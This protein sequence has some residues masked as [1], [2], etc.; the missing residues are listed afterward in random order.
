MRP[1]IKVWIEVGGRPVFGDGKLRWLE[2]IDETG[3]LRAA[4]KALAMSYRGL[5]G[6]LRAAEQR[7]GFRLIARR[8]G[9]AGG[10]GVELTE[11][12][13]ALVALYRRFRQGLD[14]WVAERFQAHLASGRAGGKRRAAAATRQASSRRRTR[15]A[16]PRRPRR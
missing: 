1:R 2:R 10:G 5:W 12:G 16:R 8:T 14:E 11:E 4:A 3:S 9:G 6:R 7:L 13:R 15:A